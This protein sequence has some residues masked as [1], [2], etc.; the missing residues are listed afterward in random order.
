MAS[1]SGYTET[2]DILTPRTLAARGS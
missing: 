1:L 2:I